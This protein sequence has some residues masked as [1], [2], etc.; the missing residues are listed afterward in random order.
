MSRLR[1]LGFALGTA[2]LALELGAWL[3]LRPLRAELD[4]RRQHAL[5]E[6]S[7]PLQR[8][9]APQ[10]RAGVRELAGTGEVV[11]PYLGFV[12]R[13]DDDR[14]GDRLE[15]LGFAGPFVR[16]AR[17]DRLVI[18][19]FGG[20]VAAGFFD[21][22]GGEQVSEGVRMLPAF[23]GRE[24]LVVRGAAGAYKQPQSWIALGYLLSLGAHFDVVIL[25][26]GFNEVAVPATL[27]EPFGGFPFYPA[28]WPLRLANLEVDTE[29]RS[30]VGEI[31]VL[32]RQRDERAREL[33]RS[34]LGRSSL[35][36][37]LWLLQDRRLDA[38]IEGLRQTLYS[39]DSERR[40]S[41]VRS[42]AHWPRSRGQLTP[43]LVETWR[44]G[45][46]LMRAICE[47]RGIRFF[48]F[49]QPNLHVPES[50]PLAPE[51]LALDPAH[52]PYAAAAREGYP[53]L[54]AAGE[55]LRAEGVS[56]HDLTPLFA[57]VREP[58]YV[59]HCC[60]VNA[61]G[62]RRIATAMAERIAAATAGT[63]AR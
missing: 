43:D 25:L 33:S 6:R 53:L 50:K 57:G 2:L 52:S 18:G 20:S 32:R 40:R 30:L 29:L 34:A 47:A 49:L 11:H 63:S 60:H 22:G 5:R 42:G 13:P 1:P 62:N 61:E 35:V 27:V 9:L 55:R 26:D 28:L 59:D 48:H 44:Q 21:Q 19:I 56:F 14:V 4:A 15:P 58:L 45:S 37:L 16:E 39:P 54:R 17:S 46:L 41:Y 3:L 10:I 12:V 8:P 38:H 36:T 31:A 23:A 51:E 24:A 7:A